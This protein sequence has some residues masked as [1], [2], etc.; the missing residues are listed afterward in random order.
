MLLPDKVNTYTTNEYFNWRSKDPKYK[1][2][3]FSEEK[4]YIAYSLNRN[5]YLII[6]KIFGKTK[7]LAVEMLHSLGKSR[8][9]FIIY[10]YNINLKNANFLATLKRD[11]LVVVLKHHEEIDA[12]K[13]LYISMAY[14]EVVF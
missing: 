7:Q 8:E 3:F 12:L 14:L 9:N 4:V 6:H 1:I 11:I 2:A 5:A 13:G 10:Y